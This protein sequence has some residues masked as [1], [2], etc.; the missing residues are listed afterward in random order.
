MAV[1]LGEP[2]H[3]GRI[4][5]DDRAQFLGDDTV[6]HIPIG[7]KGHHAHVGMKHWRA[8]TDDGFPDDAIHLPES[9]RS[10]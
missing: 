3:L 7:S 8:M 9:V 1:E 4:A 10:I 5:L 6:R 2:R